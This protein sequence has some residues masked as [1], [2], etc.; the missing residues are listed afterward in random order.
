M[1]RR[2]ILF[3]ANGTC[4]RGNSEVGIEN[5]GLVRIMLHPGIFMMPAASSTLY[6]QK[7]ATRRK[8]EKHNMQLRVAITYVIAFRKQWF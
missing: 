7:Y 8:E 5:H 1:T 6:E 2:L 3:Y 4:S